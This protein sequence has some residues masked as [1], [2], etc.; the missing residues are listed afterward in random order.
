MASLNLALVEMGGVFIELR[1]QGYEVYA[2]LAALAS[3]GSVAFQPENDKRS[4]V[5]G[6]ISGLRQFGP[7]T[8]CTD[9]PFHAPSSSPS[10]WSPPAPTTPG[11]PDCGHLRWP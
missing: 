8:A 9:R 5:S 7:A 6:S 11:R 1:S 2:F 4:A 3:Y 10:L